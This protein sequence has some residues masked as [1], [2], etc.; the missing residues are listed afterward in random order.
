MTEDRVFRGKLFTIGHLVFVVVCGFVT[1]WWALMGPW[2]VV[3]AENTLF[4]T[5]SAF[6]LIWCINDVIGLMGFDDGKQQLLLCYSLFGAIILIIRLPYFI[7]ILYQ[8][9]FGKIVVDGQKIHGTD[10]SKYILVL[11]MFS[12]MIFSAISLK[13]S[14]QIYKE[15]SASST[16]QQNVPN[17]SESKVQPL[18]EEVKAVI[19]SS[20]EMEDKSKT[21]DMD[22]ESKFEKAIYAKY[23]KTQNFLD[24]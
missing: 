18:N 10:I 17:E 4:F 12:G 8:A 20:I 11:L 19:D 13:Y 24:N 6:C 22:D 7:V 3:V 23:R 21:K 5:F 1:A 15:H 14:Y 16:S 2:A 9:I